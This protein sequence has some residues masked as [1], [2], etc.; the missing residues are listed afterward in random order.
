MGTQ[1][2][3]QSNVQSATLQ[4]QP[5]GHN[6]SQPPKSAP[7]SDSNPF[8]APNFNSTAVQHVKDPQHRPI[9]SIAVTSSNNETGKD[10]IQ[11]WY[12]SR[13]EPQTPSTFS[14]PP[15]ESQ[16][17]PETSLVSALCQAVPCFPYYRLLH[18]LQ[19]QPLIIIQWLLSRDVF[20]L[21]SVCADLRQVALNQLVSDILPRIRITISTDSVHGPDRQRESRRFQPVEPFPEPRPHSLLTLKPSDTATMPRSYRPNEFQLSNLLILF[22]DNPHPYHVLLE[23]DFKRH[24]VVHTRD[25][26]EHNFIAEFAGGAG[27]IGLKYEEQSGVL[28][29]ESLFISVE[30]LIRVVVT[31]HKRRIFGL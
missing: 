20:G 13:A 28:I 17:E 8:D 24:R 23:P 15:A 11:D 18:Q 7:K 29:L 12:I 10:T 26:T 19:A 25:Y 5:R 21:L 31:D 6:L 1:S 22:H 30:S 27:E 9:E 4:Q 16:W 3:L 14:W 2:H